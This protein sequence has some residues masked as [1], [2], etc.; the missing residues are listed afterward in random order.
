[1]PAIPRGML[2]PQA[3]PTG[4]RR[5]VAL[6]NTRPGTYERAEAAM[7]ANDRGLDLTPIGEALYRAGGQFLEMEKKRKA[8]EL[9]L[10]KIKQENAARA[11]QIE[12]TQRMYDLQNSLIQQNIDDPQKAREAFYGGMQGLISQRQAEITALGPF[13]EEAM[14]KHYTELAIKL[15]PQLTKHSIEFARKGLI[16]SLDHQQAQVMHQ[17]ATIPDDDVAADAMANMFNQI[18]EAGGAYLS[19]TES[20]QRARAFF[21]K[22]TE[23]RFRV[24]YGQDEEAAIMWL[25]EQGLDTD[26]QDKMVTQAYTMANQE[27]HR[28]DREHQLME[29]EEKASQDNQFVT[30]LNEITKLKKGNDLRGLS[31]LQDELTAQPEETFGKAGHAQ[32]LTAVNAAL[33]PPASEQKLSDQAI[34]FKLMSRDPSIPVDQ[35]DKFAASQYE[36]LGPAVLAEWATTRGERLNT[37][38]GR[39]QQG[40]KEVVRQALAIAGGGLD[41]ASI[42][43]QTSDQERQKRMLLRAQ[44]EQRVAEEKRRYLSFDSAGENNFQA[45]DANLS[46]I[47]RTVGEAFKPVVEGTQELP[48][49]IHKDINQV[50]GRWQQKNGL[51]NRLV[52]DEEWADAVNSYEQKW[53]QDHPDT[54]VSESPFFKKMR[55]DELRAQQ[56]QYK[57]LIMSLP[58]SPP[59]RN[60][61]EFN[62]QVK[63]TIA[64]GEAPAQTLE[65]MTQEAVN[66]ESQIIQAMQQAGINPEDL[67]AAIPGI[68]ESLRMPVDPADAELLQAAAQTANADWRTEVDPADIPT[69]GQ[70]QPAPTIEQAVAEAT[71]QPHENDKLVGDLR[72]AATKHNIPLPY[73]RAMADIES[74]GDP[75][76]VSSTG[77]TGIFQFTKGTGRD[78]GLITDKGDNRKNQEANIDAGARLWNANRRTLERAGISTEPWMMYMAHQQGAT[79]VRHLVEVAQGK[80]QMTAKIRRSM[81]LNG[82][83]GKTPQEFLDMWEAKWDRIASKYEG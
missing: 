28:E 51:G 53:K 73:L 24:K 60:S 62:K 37:E 58:G 6:P 52:G 8:E 18:N 68:D 67:K 83:K 59:L 20:M 75:N 47:A 26:T 72:G 80:R 56:A 19:P 71:L 2:Q 42:S 63:E 54:S 70:E 25:A 65:Q 43:L 4:G 9:A 38:Y 3:L 39:I 22:A 74:K 76:A 11:Y 48:D 45:F 13:A 78:F 50:Y 5:Q 66:Q 41:D 35:I 21:Q 34:A 40:E 61:N 1:M 79:G 32:L 30:V 29:R 44:I 31:N 46:T 49:P 57:P 69:Q 7:L 82:G 77:A 64:G 16:E 81:D 12:A 10:G 17:I 23:A 27:E 33:H 14:A 15:G 55:E 36:N